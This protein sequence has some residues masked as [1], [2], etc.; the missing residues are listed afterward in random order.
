MGLIVLQVY[1]QKSQYEVFILLLFRSP[2]D[3]H[4]FIPSGRG[5]G[6]GY[7]IYVW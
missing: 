2:V 7:F 5:R 6:Q 4:D 3:L 1:V